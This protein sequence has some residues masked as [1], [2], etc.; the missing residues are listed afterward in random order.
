MREVCAVITKGTMVDG[1]IV[2]TSSEASVM[3]SL[4]ERPLH[5]DASVLG[6]C[7]VDAST[8]SFQLGQFEDDAART[9]L[10]SILTELRPV[11]LIIPRGLLSTA[12]SRALRDYTRQPLVNDLVPVTEFWDHRKSFEEL[13]YVYSHLKSPSEK[14]MVA[15]EED[16]PH[17]LRCLNESREQGEL[18]LS[19]MGACVFYLRQAL[20]DQTMLSLQKI[21]LLPGCEPILGGLSNSGD[22][23][24]RQCGIET[25]FNKVEPY[26]VLDAAA[27]ENLEIIEN[28]NGGT[29]G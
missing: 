23:G 24:W 8:S 28:R 21:E 1:D 11:E 5:N 4:T 6:L 26:M 18:A 17:I 3:L 2:A 10:C 27:L 29:Q 16:L 15:K 12:T 19:A 9:R 25:V 20:L 7:V 22:P 14:N 13:T